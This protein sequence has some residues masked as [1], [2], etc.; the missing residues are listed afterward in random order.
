MPSL[1]ARSL[2]SRGPAPRRTAAA[3]LVLALVGALSQVLPPPAAIAAAPVLSAAPAVNAAAEPNAPMRMTVN[4]AN[5]LLLTQLNIGHEMNPTANPGFKRQLNSGWSLA[6]LWATVP[7]DL[8]NNIG[9]V[10]HQG[11]NNISDTDKTISSR[12]LEDNVREADA[13]GIPIFILWDEGVTKGSGAIAFAERLYQ[14]YPAFMGTVVSETDSTLNSLN[15]ALQLANN[16]GGFHVLGSVEESNV[17]ARHLETQANWDAAQQYRK[18]F[19]FNP[20]NFH[21]NFDSVNSWTKGAWMAGAFD[22]WGPYFDGYPYYG[23]GVFGV[24]TEYVP[25]GDRWS[26][27][28]A[29]TVSSMMMLDQWQNGATVFHLENQLDV[30]TTG[31][32]YSPHFYQ[33][34]L[35]AMRYMLAHKAVAPTR[36]SVITDTEVAFDEDAGSLLTLRDTDPTGRNPQRPTFYSMYEKPSAFTS[37]RR[38]MWFYLRSSGRY[39]IIPRIPKL[40]PSTLVSQLGGGD[41]RILTPASYDPTLVYGDARNAVLDGKY[42]QISTGDAFVQNAGN[43]WLVY[44]T[45]DR[46]NFDED[47]TVKLKGATFT[48]LQLPEITPHTWAAVTE[49]GSALSVMLDTYRTDREG[50]LIK[51]SILGRR[52]M[53]FNRN[54]VK[55]AYVPNPQ[56]GALRSTT[57]RFDVATKPTLT[58]SGYDRNN[59]S[60]T[61]EWNPNTRVYTLVVQSNGVVNIKLTTADHEVSTPWTVADPADVVTTSG[62]REFTFDG[63]SVAWAVPAGSTGTARVL[64]DGVQFAA[65]ADLSAGGT[66]FRATGLPNSVHTLRLEG[67]ALPVAAIRYVPSVEHDAS[68]LET[69]DFNYGS[70]AA[71]ESMLHGSEGWRVTQAGKLRLVGQV[72]PFVGDTSVY[73]TNAAARLANLRYEAKLKVANGTSGSLMFRANEDTK[74]SFQFRLDPLMRGEGRQSNPQP[75]YRCSLGADFGDKVV[76]LV[77]ACADTVAV[78]AGTEY[79]VVITAAGTLITVSLNGTQ[80]I[81]HDLAGTAYA[82]RTGAGHTGVRAPWTQTEAGTKGQYIEIDDVRITDLD[83]GAVA[84]Q[85]GFARWRDTTSTNDAEGWMTETPFVFDW[86]AK[87]D[88]RSSFTFPW[89]WTTSAG[90][91]AVTENPTQ[92]SGMSG[93]YTATATAGADLVTVGGD[94]VAATAALPARARAGWAANGGYDYWSWLRVTTGTRAGLVFRAASRTDNYQARIDTANQT[95]SLGKLVDGD[96]TP[97]ATAPSPVALAAGKWTLVKVTAHGPLL[98]VS[99][100]GAAVPGLSVRDTAFSGGSAGIWVPA[101]GRAEVE[102]ARVV[103]RPTRAVTAPRPATSVVAPDGIA[104]RHLTGFDHVGVKTARTKQPALPPTVSARYSDG[105]RAWVAVTWPAIAPAQLATATNPSKTGHSRGGFTIQGTVAGTSRT[106][107]ARITVLPNLT[108]PTTVPGTTYSTAARNFPSQ[109]PGEAT[110]SDGSTTWRKHLY[111]RWHD[112]P[113]T[114]PGAPATQTIRGTIGGVPW[115][116]ISSTMTVTP[117]SGTTAPS[118][119][120]SVRA[121]SGAGTATLSW[122]APLADGGTTVTGYRVTAAPGGASCTTSGASS[123]T[124]SGL[125]D[126][127]T[128]TFTVTATNAAGTSAASAPTWPVTPQRTP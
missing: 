51:P 77:K 126:G 53:E 10:L 66:V 75:T 106:V 6:Q 36:S 21:E 127:T 84:Y 78:A 90:S 44:N 31:S 91:W 128:Y 64:I 39:D 92:T 8:K 114:Q 115:D 87:A 85:S 76:P 26:R 107:P 118:V 7:D 59:Y 37:Q 88:P 99:V 41:A 71:D 48:Q 42:P 125:T 22:N 89:Q 11:H 74:Q 16:Y 12:W 1:P 61:E 13:L 55:Y 33:S 103:A 4:S 9:F 86:H 28:I 81:S 54:Y 116:T 52:D 93:I 113:V 23:C 83:T 5:P 29:E 109:T 68:S 57:L 117:Q 119:P 124:V 70:E 32:L 82:G 79:D 18:N 110:F 47:A 2:P 120:R 46:D 122:T 45:N 112:T 69:N 30:P 20:K 38:T 105:T 97:I 62:A 102:D 17:L 15:A 49:Q 14:N 104:G 98:T 108:G 43:T 63:T 60:Y 35:P 121:V 101:G 100:G 94:A 111:V 67:A 58:I 72:F 50:D 24:K 3:V 65:A 25:C 73:H 56:D 34:I 27:S 80:V 123:C 96:W 40:A 95:V 19:I